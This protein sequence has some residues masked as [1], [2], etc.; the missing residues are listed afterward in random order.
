MKFSNRLTLSAL[1]LFVFRRMRRRFIPHQNWLAQAKDATINRPEER[2]YLWAIYCLVE[3]RYP[4]AQNQ[5]RHHRLPGGETLPM[6]QNQGHHDQWL[7]GETLPAGTTPKTSL[8]SAWWT[9]TTYSTTYST[10]PRTSWSTAWWRDATRRHKTKDATINLLV[11]KRNLW[12]Q[13]Q[14]RHRQ[15]PGGETLPK[16]KDV[17]MNRLE[18]RR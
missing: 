2:R 4:K 16:T 10:T 6:A 12:A 5:R 7:G 8:S 11:E 15:L 14:G 17:R 1:V 18:K 3:I 9:D 13:R